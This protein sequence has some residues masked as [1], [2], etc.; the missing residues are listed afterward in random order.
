MK[1]I[2]S[3]ISRLNFRNGGFALPPVDEDFGE[4]AYDL[5][6]VLFGNPRGYE[7][8]VGEAI[9]A[10]CPELKIRGLAIPLEVFTRGLNQRDMTA[11]GVG[12]GASL[13]QTLRAPSIQD[14]LRP[15]SAVTR[16]GAQFLT[17]LRD[18]I[19]L[20]RWEIASTPQAALE[21][22]PIT[23]NTQTLSLLSLKPHRI[24]SATILS[25]RLMKQAS[26]TG[27]NGIEGLIAQEMLASIGSA[28]DG[29]ALNGSG[30]AGQ[31]LGL[32]NTGANLPGSR[33][34]SLLSPEV[35][36]GAAPSWPKICSFIGNVE[37]N[38]IVS[39][40]STVWIVSP[41][42]REKWIS[43]EKVAGYPSYL[44]ENGT[45]A[46]FPMLATNNLSGTGGSHRAVYGRWSS[47][48][49]AIWAMSVLVD[50]VSLAMS[51]HVRVFVDL[52][53]DCGPIYAPAFCAS[54]DAGNQ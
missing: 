34:L 47:M 13:V 18:N 24:S 1:T 7:R 12:T 44:S 39:D 22:A 10:R 26:D 6:S 50:N 38:D 16:A 42:T 19:S 9:Q 54:S 4:K 35:T 43:T 32:L 23:P 5:R 2:L 36:F 30:A 21:T 20:P 45:C 51:G 3:P 29:F 52:W 46:G 14:A 53:A 48:I 28:L 33:D 8:E 40:D 15:F 37:S 27:S 31:P 49:V 11:V 25:R 41:A 17:E